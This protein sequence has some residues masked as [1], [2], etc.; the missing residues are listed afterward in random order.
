ME[1]NEKDLIIL[2]TGYSI[3][4]QRSNKILDCYRMKFPKYSK[5]F[6]NINENI[7]CKL[8]IEDI[9]ELIKNETE[10]NLNLGGNFKMSK[11]L[12]IKVELRKAE[13]EKNPELRGFADVTMGGFVIRDVAVKEKET[14]KGPIVNFDMPNARKYQTEEGKTQYISAVEIANKDD[15]IKSNIIREVRKALTDA[16]AQTEANEY[17]RFVSERET[18][19]NFDEEHITSFV[20]PVE[21]EKDESLKGFATVY[22]GGVLKLNDIAVREFQNSETGE[23]F[24]AIQMPQKAVEKDGETTYKDKVFPIETGLRGKLKESIMNAYTEEI[25]KEKEDSEEEM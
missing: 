20:K 1:E 4:N 2:N 17:G 13:S 23:T 11:N 16:L 7:N 25:S 19:I 24:N 6:E 15:N 12:K 9:S 3:A 8:N 18:T 14:E 21:T 22:I 10:E 5:L